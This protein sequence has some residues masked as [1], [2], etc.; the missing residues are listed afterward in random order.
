MNILRRAGV[1]GV[2]LLLGV[3]LQFLGGCG[4][5]DHP[6]PPATVVPEAIEDLRYD[7]DAKGITL[8]WSYPMETVK[9]KEIENLASFELYRAEVPL[10]DYCGGCPIPFAEP[11]EQPGGV[12]TE[13]GK[14]RRAVYTMTGLRPGYKYFFKVRSRTS[15]F[16]ESADSNIV[17]F[18]WQVPAKAPEGLK[19]EVG[20]REIV[21]KWQPVTSLQNGD[22][23]DKPLQYQIMRS[24]G[25]K[26]F[27]KIGL[28]DRGTSFVDRKVIKNQ[29]YAYQVQTL[30]KVEKETVGGG[31]SSP[32]T[33]LSVDQ[34]A[35]APP[36]G[37]TAIE[38]DM[39]IKVF[40]EKS[41]EEDIGGYRVYRRTAA[42]KEAVPIGDVQPAYTLFV[43]QKVEQG[44]RY[45][46]SVTA[47]DQNT[48]ANESRKSEEATTRH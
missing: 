47:F 1:A 37:V 30:M 19:A 4:Y 13:D 34:T 5:K 16:A 31:T 7:A 46:Y 20:N 48:P 26:D 14:R 8:S 17:T 22:P 33:A 11:L 2:C 21:L 24:T 29:Q 28:V 40:W 32:V 43:D 38:T 23:V 42:A 3:S 6:V 41:T 25:G 35:P 45:F 12:T 9:G 15:W 39:G 44:V 27:E 10:K 36:T 18:V